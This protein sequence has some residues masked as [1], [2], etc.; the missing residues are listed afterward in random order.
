MIELSKEG[1]IYTITMNNGE[2]MICLDWHQRMLE[3]LDQLEASPVAGTAMVL[4]GEG[5][6]F[7]NGLNLQVLNKLDGADW[8]LF[9]A[10]MNEI[11][12]RMLMLP[13]PTV[14]AVNGHAFAGG[15]FMALS[16]DY[17]IMRQDRGWI[18][19][20]EVDAGVPLPQG[21]MEFL[22]LRLPAN[23]VRDAVLTGKRYN[24]EDA[25]AAGFA[26]GKAPAE[27]LLSMATELAQDLACKEPS[28]FKAIKQVYY[29]P[30]VEGLK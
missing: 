19:I 30:I 25:I 10:Q 21:M 18:C 3:I 11:H 15:A 8:T 29:A 4:I 14:A 28:I 24:A 22:R 23:T 13:F 9:A 7:S 27:L 6:F 20:S 17:R 1:T 2:N 16:C 26:D 12:R 5:K